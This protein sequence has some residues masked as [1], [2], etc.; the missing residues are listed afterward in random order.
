MIDDVLV[1]PS[2]ASK[3]FM[4]SRSSYESRRLATAIVSTASQSFQRRMSEYPIVRLD[5]DPTPGGTGWQPLATAVTPLWH[6]IVTSQQ[7]V[8]GASPER[9]STAQLIPA[10]DG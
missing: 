4:R 10:S 2:V 6:V 7:T 9:R 1:H 3:A 5:F 8:A